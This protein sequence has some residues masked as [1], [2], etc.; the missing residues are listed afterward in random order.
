MKLINALVDIQACGKYGHNIT[1]LYRV[2]F[3]AYVGGYISK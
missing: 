1:L 3:M 2:E